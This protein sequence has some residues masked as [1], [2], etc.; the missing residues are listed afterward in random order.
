MINVST[1][2]LEMVK[3]SKGRFDISK[4]VSKPIDIA[5]FF[6]QV[7]SMDKLA[8]EKFV[9]MTFNT[10]NV[11]T[12]VF[13]ISHGSL[14]ASIVHPR[15]TFKRALLVNAN[16]IAFAHNHPSGDTSPSSEDIQ[17]TKRLIEAGEI[18]GIKVL[19]HI[20]IGENG[21]YLSLRE[22]NYANF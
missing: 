3:E 6:N 2:R 16:S 15:E 12:G 18:I 19:D 13:E 1:Y 9:M 21:N 17:I 20:I 10:K 8:E 4:K 11:V 14:N 5:N 7:F 22:E